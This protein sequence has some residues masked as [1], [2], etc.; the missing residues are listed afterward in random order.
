MDMPAPIAHHPVPDAALDA[1][2]RDARTQNGWLDKP[3]SD[4][5]IQ[6]VYELM[7]FGP[8]SANCQP[9]RIVFVRTP[10][11]K[12][13]LRAALS[14]GNVDKTMAAPVVAIIGYDMEFYEQLPKLMPHIDARSW[15]VGKPEHIFN[16]AFRNSSLQGGYFILAA[17]S[18]G[19]DCGPMSGFDHKIMDETFWAGTN[20]R[21]NFI[22]SLGHGDPAKVFPR[23][24]RL[25]FNEACTLL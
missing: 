19:L 6:A 5:Q 23:S 9:A 25:A 4:A 12:E 17:R 24:P 16:T 22:C 21:T 1:L 8:T 7:K 15:F 20:V 18:V 14:P 11:G 13:K 3:V 2:F 10:E